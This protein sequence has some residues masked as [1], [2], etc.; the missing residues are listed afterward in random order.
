M[1]LKLTKLADFLYMQLRARETKGG[2][3]IEGETQVK[4]ESGYEPFLK[5]V[6]SFGSLSST[7]DVGLICRVNDSDLYVMVGYSAHHDQLC[8]ALLDQRICGKS[9]LAAGLEVNEVC[10]VAEA[11]KLFAKAIVAR[12][13]LTTKDEQWVQI[14]L[15]S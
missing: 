3:V 7:S 1:S 14:G 2:C 10:F 6:S 4:T 9:K 5:V 15:A 11:W 13:V 12:F 8:M